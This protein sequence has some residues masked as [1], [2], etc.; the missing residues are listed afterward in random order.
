MTRIMLLCALTLP[1][2]IGGCGGE[3]SPRALNG[4]LGN[5]PDYREKSF[6]QE[7]GRVVRVGY[8]TAGDWGKHNQSTFRVTEIAPDGEIL[9]E[10]WSVSASE[11]WGKTG[12]RAAGDAMK[13]HWVDF[14]GDGI[15]G[16]N[17]TASAVNGPVSASATSN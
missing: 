13:F 4:I 16:A 5:D 11:D 1:M 17:V 14:N 12:T 6:I 10:K 9:N 15:T 3:T 8:A 7:D 2:F